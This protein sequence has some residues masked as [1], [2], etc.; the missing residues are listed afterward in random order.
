MVVYH[1]LLLL[2]RYDGMQVNNQIQTWTLYGYEFITRDLLLDELIFFV[3]W[4]GPLPDDGLSTHLH[5]HALVE[6]CMLRRKEVDLQEVFDESGSELLDLAIGS[7]LSLTHLSQVVDEM[8]AAHDVETPVRLRWDMFDDLT[9]EVATTH[10]HTQRIIINK[11]VHIDSLPTL[12]H[13]VVLFDHL[14]FPVEAD[15]GVD[16]ATLHQHL[17][18]MLHKQILV[19]A[20]NQ[21][22]THDDLLECFDELCVLEERTKQLIF[23]AECFLLLEILESL[24]LPIRPLLGVQAFKY[25]Q[26]TL[27]RLTVGIELL[28]TLPLWD[29][30]FDLLLTQIHQLT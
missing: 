26:H 9:E 17:H 4:D 6:G 2:R 21:D 1:F 22:G 30:F 27:Q 12:H 14:E 19:L 8:E 11:L 15:V 23:L 13:H 25:L 24:V 29:Y 16:L 10:V 3:G 20:P 28:E 5:H 18:I 7:T